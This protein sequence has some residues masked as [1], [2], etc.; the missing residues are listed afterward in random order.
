[1]SVFAY[2]CGLTGAINSLSVALPS[3]LGLPAD[4]QRAAT[5]VVASPLGAGFLLGPVIAGGSR[6]VPPLSHPSQP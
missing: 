5:S 2:S 1:M 6:P 4:E 3:T